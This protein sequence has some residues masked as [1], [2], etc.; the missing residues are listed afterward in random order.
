MYVPTCK[1]II[2]IINIVRISIN[3]ETNHFLEKNITFINKCNVYFLMIMIVGTG[4]ELY[5]YLCTT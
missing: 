1:K 3:L 2:F 5:F 4:T